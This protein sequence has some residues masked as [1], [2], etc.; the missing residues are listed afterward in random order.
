MKNI[1]EFWYQNHEDMPNMIDLLQKCSKPNSLEDFVKNS[2]QQGKK[3]KKSQHN[4]LKI[5]SF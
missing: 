5:R 4:V 3:L 1:G 2:L